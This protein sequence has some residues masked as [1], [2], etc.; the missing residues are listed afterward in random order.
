M[1]SNY[2][3]IVANETVN[4]KNDSTEMHDEIDRTRF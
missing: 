2:D 4:F 3:I 1:A